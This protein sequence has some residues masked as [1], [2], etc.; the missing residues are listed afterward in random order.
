MQFT[1][2][3]F[4]PQGDLQIALTADGKQRLADLL[5]KYIDWN[6]DEVFLE[7]IDEQLSKEWTIIPPEQ[8]RATRALLILSNT[9][10]YDADG[11][12]S[13]VDSAYW[14]PNDLLGMVSKILLQRGYGCYTHYTC[15]TCEVNEGNQEEP[16][17]I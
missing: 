3:S 14:H 4:T 6:D 16:I 12:L 7:L 17:W 10:H 11:N 15:Y 1:E 9:A 2:F 5:T 13:H 8:I